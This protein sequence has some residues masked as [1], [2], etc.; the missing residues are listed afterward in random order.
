M[1]ASEREYKPAAY[2]FELADALLPGTFEI[3]YNLGE[4]YIQTGNQVK[5][6]ETLKLALTL[7]PDSADALYRLGK[8]YTDQRRYIQAMEVLIKAH[9]L[10][11]RDTDIIFLL[12]RVSM[13][14][15]YFED[16]IPLLEAGIEVAPQRPDLHAALGESLF[17]AGQI[18]KAQQQFQILVRL[19]PSSSSYNFLGLCY[20]HQGQFEEAKK[21]FQK[22]IKLNPKYAPC[23]FNL[24]Y[25]ENKQGNPERAAALLEQAIQA[26]PNYAS[27]LFELAS[28]RMTQKKYE[29]AIPLLR[30]CTK[31]TS[32]PARAYYKISIAERAL[33]QTPAAD[34]DLKVFETLSK[35][36]SPASFPFQ[37]FIET[38]DQRTQ[39]PSGERNQVETK[40]LLDMAHRNPGQ[41]ST[42]YLL[43]EA[44]LEHG[45]PA[46]AMKWISEL[47]K[48]S[49]GDFRTALGVGV[50][51][52]RYRL[53]EEALKHFQLAVEADPTADDAKYDLANSYFV[54]RQYTQ[55]LS[56]LQQASPSAQSDDTILA[57]LADIYAHLGQT[58]EAIGIFATALK[59]NPENENYCLSLAMAH[60]RAANTQ[61][62]EEV[63][64]QGLSR[65][66]DSPLL[67]WGVGVVSAIDGKPGQAEEFLDKGINLMPD[68]V[69][70]YSVL[71]LFYFDSGQITKA[72]EVM[73]RCKRFASAGQINTDLIA[74]ALDAAGN[75]ESEAKA[76]YE[77][78]PA[79]RSQLLQ[80]ALTLA[81]QHP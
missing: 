2:Q 46:E 6:E 45:E 72:R 81:D 15:Y 20:R 47:D 16:A 56:V 3:L 80:L 29:E 13:L 52:E 28:V 33:H 67:F 53:Y 12:S 9:Q 77:L 30:R 76:P 7:K 32:N 14:Q 31:V 43:A 22:G 79:A 75:S 73:G 61:A 62:A 70:G 19:D 24:G 49:G 34:R 78:S 54:L 11:P 23:L 40:E 60:L 57:L 69:G 36:P 37:H 35:E 38:F 5:A 63:L 25:I 10:A 39:L 51:L 50:L 58:K 55:A 1:L 8:L 74:K 64:R 42:L 4:A 41:P 65:V 68:W 48:L 17:N 21:Y 66:P 27:A 71:G 26:D 44:Y 18:E 59:T